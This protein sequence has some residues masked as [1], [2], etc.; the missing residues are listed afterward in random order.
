MVALGVYLARRTGLK[1]IAALATVPALAILLVL[2]VRAG[3]I[4]SYRNG[5]TPIEMLVYTQ[6]TPD[7]TRLLGEIKAAGVAS[8]LDV[9]ITIDG[10][11]GF[12]W[13]WAWY[14][15]DTPVGYPAFD[16]APPE[17]A[18]DTS[19]LLVHSQN[20]ASVEPLLGDAYDDGERIRHRWW[21][22]ED[23]YRGLTPGKFVRGLFDRGTWRGGIDYFLYRKGVEDRLGSEDAYRYYSKEFQRGP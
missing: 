15:R 5:D 7:V 22:P 9:S 2:S 4:L 3:W 8:G 19:V 16:G 6:T 12:S 20:K 18:P 17:Q 10:T 1:E 11:S 21:F 13:P 14:L 23:T